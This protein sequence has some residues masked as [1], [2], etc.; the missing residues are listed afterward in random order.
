MQEKLPRF[1][2]VRL[3]ACIPWQV[4]ILDVPLV[5]LV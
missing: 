2:G 4:E 3:A 5:N 1:K